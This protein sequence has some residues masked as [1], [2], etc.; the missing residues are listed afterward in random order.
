[1]SKTSVNNLKRLRLFFTRITTLSNAIQ[2]KNYW[3]NIY[4]S[5][6]DNY[7]IK[8]DKITFPN[9]LEDNVN[10]QVCS[11]CNWMPTMTIIF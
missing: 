9:I 7:A 5:T 11:Y 6:Y 3:I 10:R 8:D 4:N 2:R 1:M